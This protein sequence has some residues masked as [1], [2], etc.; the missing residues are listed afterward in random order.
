MTGTRIS[1]VD[2]ELT[3]PI[4]DIICSNEETEI[5]LNHCKTCDQFTQSSEVTV[6]AATQCNINLMI[7]M[8]FKICPKEHWQ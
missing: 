5:R 7:T 2:T 1:S 8:K 3:T 6:C 4:I